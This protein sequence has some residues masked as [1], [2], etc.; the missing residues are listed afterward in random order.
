[1]SGAAPS[2]EFEHE[3]AKQVSSRLRRFDELTNFYSH[4]C[5]GWC[6]QLAAEQD[7]LGLNYDEDAKP[8]SLGDREPLPLG[9]KVFETRSLEEMMA[10]EKGEI[11]RALDVAVASPLVRLSED[12]EASSANHSP[13]NKNPDAA[14][15]R[16]DDEN[17]DTVAVRAEAAALDA[18]VFKSA[19]SV[20]SRATTDQRVLG[21]ADL[22]DEFERVLGGG[23]F[24]DSV[25]EIADGVDVDRSRGMAQLPTTTPPPPPPAA[26][27]PGPGRRGARRR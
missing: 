7:M 13:K 21:G 19:S 12:D 22:D 10:Q 23:L 26:E 17:D 20:S 3:F 8:T 18:R 6:V 25:K 1:M 9:G 11:E 27:E 24:I 5:S 14:H 15:D 2:A 4:G 16:V